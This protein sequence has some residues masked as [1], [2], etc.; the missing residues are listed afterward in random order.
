[1]VLLLAMLVP[2]GAIRAQGT[3]FV[4]DSTNDAGDANPSD[5]VCDDGTGKCTLRAAI[6]E[7]NALPGPDTIDVPSGTYTLSIGE[8]SKTRLPP[9]TSTSPTT[10]PLLALA[11]RS[12]AEAHEQ[13][14]VTSA[15]STE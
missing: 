2:H 9:E 4:V 6:M 8:P 12:A 3:A 5:W 13:G 15:A 14:T 11:A 7:A 1:M 10:C